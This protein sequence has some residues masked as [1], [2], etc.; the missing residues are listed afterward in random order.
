MS[1]SMQDFEEFKKEYEEFSKKALDSCDDGSCDMPQESFDDYPDFVRAIYNEIM[2]PAKSGIYFSR[3]DIKAMAAEVDEHIIMDVRERM[4]MHFM[5]SIVTKE[6]MLKVVE[7]F[8]KHIDMKCELYN[9]YIEK[10]PS[11]API[12]EQNISKATKA[13]RFL[14]K[15]IKDYFE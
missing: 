5:R 6:D 4:F 8:N 9:E 14:Q 7:Q 15:V 11:S 10:Y 1:L 12:F 3:W 13:K 2:P